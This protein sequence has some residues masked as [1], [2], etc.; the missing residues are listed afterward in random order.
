MKKLPLTA[1]R[2]FAAILI[3]SMVQFTSSSAFAQSTTSDSGDV[4]IQAC[5]DGTMS[6]AV[7]DGGETPDCGG[8][9]GCLPRC[10]PVGGYVVCKCY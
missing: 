4:T 3:S 7:S 10:M 2:F 1:V 8:G 6:G 5:D 9:Y